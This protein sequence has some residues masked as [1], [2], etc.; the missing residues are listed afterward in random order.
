MKLN[1]KKTQTHTKKGRTKTTQNS[2]AGSK[3]GKRKMVKKNCKEVRVEKVRVVSNEQPN[4]N[5]N[6]STDSKL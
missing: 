3:T 2:K 4:K 1:F 6:Q 5:T